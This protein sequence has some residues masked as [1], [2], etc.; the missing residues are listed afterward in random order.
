MTRLT[1]TRGA[2]R[3]LLAPLLHHT[4]R[5]SDRTPDLGR[6]RLTVTATHLVAWTTDDSVHVAT[7][8]TAHHEDGELDTFDLPVGAVQA[9]LAVFRP[10]A[11]STAR[12][13]WEERELCWDVTGEH[14]HL[15]EVGDLLPGR[16]LR[17]VRATSIDTYPD[18]PRRLSEVL[19]N[20]LATGPHRHLDADPTTVRK[21]IASTPG[22][23]LRLGERV[24][25][26]ASPTV[27]AA[28][29]AATGDVVAPWLEDEP[30]ADLTAWLEALTPLRSPVRT[31]VPPAMVDVLVRQI[32]EHLTATGQDL[33]SVRLSITPACRVCG[34][35]DD[36]AC[37]G[38]CHW[39]EPGLCSACQDTP[40][41][42][43]EVA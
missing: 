42:G 4:G 34:C 7:R 20:L 25:V 8:A 12:Q 27:V 38:G 21:V 28:A 33:D 36:E 35:T 9:A 32:E 29:P 6:V 3:A 1:T 15:T 43:G 16:H 10:P 18:V 26:W 41:G 30:L 31:Q 37:E 19:G 24:A 40:A 13:V 39:V 23:T 22:A 2:A 14:V 17:V 11:D 5:A